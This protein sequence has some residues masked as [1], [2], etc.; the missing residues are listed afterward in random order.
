MNPITSCSSRI[1][2]VKLLHFHVAIPVCNSIVC[3][4]PLIFKSLL[5]ISI[6][7]VAAISFDTAY[8]FSL[9][10]T[11]SFNLCLLYLRSLRPALVQF[12]PISPG[13][14]VSYGAPTGVEGIAM[15]MKMISSAITTL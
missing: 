13:L 4:Y 10:S 2:T 7:A 8:T 14:S 9:G 1:L 11:S 15:M 5:N 12:G 6:I 3:V